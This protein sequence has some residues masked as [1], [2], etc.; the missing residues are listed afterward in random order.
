MPD[1]SAL[2][3]AAGRGSRAGLPYPKTLFEI[4]G[5]PILVRI[6][7][8]LGAHDGRPTVVVSP[9]GEEPIRKRL[10]HEG[11]DAHLVTQHEPRGMGDAVMRFVDSP[12][13]CAADHVLLIWGDVPFI[14]TS[15]IATMVLAHRASDNDFTFVTRV[16]DHPYTVV[17]RDDCGRVLGVVET[18][19]DGDAPPSRGERDVGLFIFRK[20]AVLDMLARDFPGKW[21]RSTGEHGF[22]YIIRHLVESGL[23]VEALPIADETE[24]VSLNRLQDLE[25]FV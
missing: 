20:D 25:R 23:K 2:I 17:A 18:R 3:A 16:V 11:L 4:G 12:A 21:G 15:T 13:Y 7:E 8:Q 1:V 22:L 10:L 5:K 14:R 24:I 9:S 6:F 19:E